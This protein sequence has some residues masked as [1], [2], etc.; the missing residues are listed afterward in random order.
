MTK[1]ERLCDSLLQRCLWFITALSLH[2]GFRRDTD[3]AFAEFWARE[4]QTLNKMNFME[5]REDNENKSACQPRELIESPE[6]NPY[7]LQQYCLSPEAFQLIEKYNLPFPFHYNEIILESNLISLEIPI[8]KYIEEKNIF[9]INHICALAS[10][11]IKNDKIGIKINLEYPKKEIMASLDNIMNI[12][13]NERK[14]LGKKTKIRKEKIDFNIFKIYEKY[15]FKR[16]K[17]WE[18][19]KEIYPN[20]AKRSPDS[21][22]DNFDPNARRLLRKVERDY[23]KAKKIISSINPRSASSF[24]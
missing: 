20:I 4:R 14:R 6:K 23:K 16:K 1:K 24:W 8:I 5:S 13:L 17:F 21:F 9:L 3:E 19:T 2:P 12:V 22:H 15:K 10:Y 7:V 11:E 18:I